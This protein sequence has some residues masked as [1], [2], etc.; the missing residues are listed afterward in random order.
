[1]IRAVG[2]GRG[3]LWRVRSVRGGWVGGVV[4]YC[5]D[6]VCFGEGVDGGGE[7]G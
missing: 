5:E 2:V 3:V 6:V 1:M 4:E 7:E